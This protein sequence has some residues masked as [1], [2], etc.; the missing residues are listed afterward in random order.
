MLSIAF[1]LYVFL[2]MIAVAAFAIFFVWVVV[3]WVALLSAKRNAAETTANRSGT[4]CERSG[5]AASRDDGGMSGMRRRTIRGLT[6]GVMST[7]P[8]A[9]RFENSLADAYRRPRRIR[10]AGAG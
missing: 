9:S 4:S 5:F 8:A 1:G 6:G 7:L 3:V 2:L 10:G